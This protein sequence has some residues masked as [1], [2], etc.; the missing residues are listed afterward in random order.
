ME[1]GCVHAVTMNLS[2]QSLHL[3]TNHLPLQYLQ[4]PFEV[5]IQHLR[6]DSPALFLMLCNDRGLKCLKP[7]DETC[8]GLR[9]ETQE[10]SGGSQT[11]I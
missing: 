7:C 9:T 8:G 1:P 6:V 11:S 4:C 5:P 3:A 10:T 2:Y